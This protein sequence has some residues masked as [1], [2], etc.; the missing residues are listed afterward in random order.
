MVSLIFPHFQASSSPASTISHMPH[1]VGHFFLTV[2]ACHYVSWW[3]NQTCMPLPFCTLLL[4]NSH[5]ISS[6]HFLSA[7]FSKPYQWLHWRVHW[8][9]G[10]A[11]S[12]PAVFPF[13]PTYPHSQFILSCITGWQGPGTQTIFLVYVWRASEVLSLTRALWCYIGTTTTENTFSL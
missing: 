10:W 2:N 3:D 5:M 8:W 9:P 6:R 1:L 7:L 12:P 11:F 4:S 13:T